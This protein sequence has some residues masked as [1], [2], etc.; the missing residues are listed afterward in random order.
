MKR[1]RR[2][3]VL[4]WGLGKKKFNVGHDEVLSNKREEKISNNKFIT[5]LSRHRKIWRN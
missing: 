2:G 4:S 5:E 3:N 1:E